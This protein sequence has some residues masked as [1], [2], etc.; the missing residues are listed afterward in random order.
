MIKH[1]NSL[2]WQLW[3]QY[4]FYVGNRFMAL[5][6]CRLAVVMRRV[7]LYCPAS[8]GRVRVISVDH[9]PGGTCL[10]VYSTSSVSDRTSSNVK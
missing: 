2:T 6:S 7:A 4:G 8:R 1:H 9:L 3:L 10:L 5:P